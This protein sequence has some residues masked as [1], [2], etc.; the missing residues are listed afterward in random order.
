MTR[1]TILRACTLAAC[2]AALG[3][4]K[5]TAPAHAEPAATTP[6]A[7]T[8]VDLQELIAGVSGTFLSAETNAAS[9]ALCWNAAP[10]S[11]EGLGNAV[12]FEVARADDLSHPFSQGILHFYERQGQ[13]RL[14]QFDFRNPNMAGA[15]TWLWLVPESFP[16]IAIKDL[17]VT[18][19]LAADGAAPASGTTNLRTLAPFPTT[20]EGATELQSR[21]T[22]KEDTLI[23]EDHGFD[24]TGKQVWGGKPGEGTTFVRRPASVPLPITVARPAEGLVVLEQAS[25]DPA[26]TPVPEGGSVALHYTG[27]LT[28]G[29]QFDTSRGPD[30]SPFTT[31]VPGQV[32][33]GFNKGLVGIAKGAK[34]R[35]FIPS[36]FAY[37]ARGAGGVIPPNAD[38]IFEVECMAMTPPSAPPVTPEP[39][40]AAPAEKPGGN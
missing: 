7:A 9:P 36:V 21:L 23:A 33:P 31:S 40:P 35:L 1:T 18:N 25:D 24:P 5:S 4:G 30:G 11:V 2:F 39:T 19:E 16:K 38:L 27:W 13:L 22:I 15:V 34:R 29:T 28:N 8:D 20:R 17:V 3:A 14:R 12:Y 10:V 37:G 26:A 6:L 32:I